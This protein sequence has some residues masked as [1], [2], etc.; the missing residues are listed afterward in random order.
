MGGR[1]ELQLVVLDRF[2]KATTKKRSPTFF[3]E[4]VRP[5][6]KSWLRLW[7]AARS[8]KYLVQDIMLQWSLSALLGAA[9]LWF[10]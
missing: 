1:L 9:S 4:K 2:L 6:T 7:L 10:W 3:E 5:E 8:L